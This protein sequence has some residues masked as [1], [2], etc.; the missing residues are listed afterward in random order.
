MFRPTGP[1]TVFF[2][3]IFAIGF[4]ATD[5]AHADTLL[6]DDFDAYSNDGELYTIWPPVSGNGQDILAVDHGKLV[7]NPGAV[8][9]RP[10]NDN[11]PAVQGGAVSHV[12]GSINEY[13]G[14]E[15]FAVPEEGE[16][17]RVTGDIFD[18][19]RGN[20]R[21]SIGLR[22]DLISANLVELGFWNADTFDPTMPAQDPDSVIPTT[23]FAYR[24]ALFGSIGDGLARS[25]NWQYFQL[26]ASF[27]SNQDGLVEPADIGPGWHRYVATIG[28]DSISFELDLFRDG[29]VD[30]EQTWNMSPILDGDGFAFN[31]FRFGGASGVSSANGAVFDNLRLELVDPDEAFATGDFTRDGNLDC[32]D[33]DPLVRDIVAGT[34]NAVFDLDGDGSVQLED[35]DQW[36]ELAATANGFQ[37]PYRHG[38]ATL[39]GAVDAAD[40]NQLGVNWQQDPNGWCGGD[41]NADGAADA[42]DLNTLAVAWNSQLPTAASAV[43]EPAAEPLL[44]LVPWLVLLRRDR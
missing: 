12:G 38:D 30:A 36:L 24:T 17:I 16:A 33:I 42:A 15:F 4:A 22:H 1:I 37:E 43:P 13:Q 39:D 7:P 14:H 34:N 44:L 35:L 3:A 20:K 29:I 23:G 27:D 5:L 6:F 2:V 21:M 26:P 9:V 10:P 11:P 25:P 31:S 28:I 8:G 32:G 19:A 18:D 41:F 40:L